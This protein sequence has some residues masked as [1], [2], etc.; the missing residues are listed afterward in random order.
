VSSRLR[1]SDFGLSNDPTRTALFA[2]E[3]AFTE[4]MNT[5]AATVEQAFELASGPNPQDH[6]TDVMKLLEHSTRL[7]GNAKELS[8]YVFQNKALSAEAAT[9]AAASFGSIDDE[10]VKKMRHSLQKLSVGRPPITRKAHIRA[11]EFM[12]QS[13]KNSLGIA[14]TKFCPCGK[15][16]DA[17]CTQR[18]KT[19]IRSLKEVLRKYAPDIVVKYDS[20]H[21]DRAK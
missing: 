16:H 21:P 11:F 15:R 9:R 2:L 3:E 17:S 20:L 18:F 14:A 1:P 6:E 8:R 5:L 19:G 13:K 4:T 10:W 7:S 12:L